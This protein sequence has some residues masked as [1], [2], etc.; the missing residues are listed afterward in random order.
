M[1]EKQISK[2][3]LWDTIVSPYIRHRDL[4]FSGYGSCISCNKTITYETCDAGHFIPKSAGEW[5]RWNEENIHAQCPNC[6]RFGSQDT[7]ANYYKNL[8]AKIGQEKTDKLLELKHKKPKEERT[9][10]EIRDY[11][12]K[13]TL[14]L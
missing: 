2:T 14:T 5:F 12:K 3:Y 6:N 8:C 1:K 9:L 13:L 7:G 11:Y 10:N 4:D